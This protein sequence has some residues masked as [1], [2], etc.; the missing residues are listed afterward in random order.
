M[1]TPRTGPL[2]APPG[3][4]PEAPARGG[5]VR[6]MVPVDGKPACAGLLR[7]VAALA[8]PQGIPWLAVH[9]E[10]PARFRYARAEEE[11]LADHL[12]LAERLGAEVI[13]IQPSGL[14]AAPDFLA[15]A[16]TRQVTTL[17][18][19]RSRR[20]RWLNR[21]TGSFL[22]D[23]VHGGRELEVRVIPYFPE[24]APGRPGVAPFEAPGLRRI[25]TVL[26]ATV[27]ATAAGFLARPYLDLADIIMLYMLCIAVVAAR[28]GRWA[29]LLATGLGIAALDFFFVPPRFTLAVRD[30]RHLGT[31]GIML[32]VGWMVANLAEHIRAQA[33]MALERERHTGALYRMGAVLAEGGPV[34]AIRTR[35][36]GYLAGEL[37][38]PAVLLLAD[39]KG[40][41]QPRG[42]SGHTLDPDELAV[43]Q[44]A[45]EHG[46]PTGR[47]TRNLPG[48]RALFLPL[49]QT[50]HPVGVL[51]WFGEAA[52]GGLDPDR[53]TLL[54]T[55][56]SQI[57]LALE[58]ARLAEER[59]EARIRAEHEHLR[60]TLLSTLSHDLRTP[61]GTITGATTTL[62]EPGPEAS[63]ED[64]RWLLATIHQEAGRLQRL[65]NNLLDL[66][67]LETGE[68]R[69]AKEWI[70]VEE[71]VGSALSRLEEPLADRP[72]ELRLPEAWVPLDPVLF[73][74]VLLNLLDNALKF[75]PAGSPLEI[76][77][78]VTDTRAVWTVADR[79]PGIPPG[80]EERIFDK[81]FRGR[82]TSGTPGAGLGLAICRGIIQAHGGTIRADA[83]PGPGARFIIE[84]P[85]DG[86]PPDLSSETP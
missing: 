85:I 72:L 61:L 86:Q 45:L 18:L 62:L 56:G 3:A 69:V 67:R 33:R 74:Q 16:R 48:S 75:S 39:A 79:G 14:R 59:T 52:G 9:C 68:V 20:P 22:E 35:V 6:W 82:G 43:A 7:A 54:S 63:P 58:R 30:L 51:A 12:R 1:D 40:G 84:L 25:G 37:G 2:P 15:L 55:L 34:E 83:G 19:G 50:E 53:L 32:G 21:L 8:A 36:E 46:E 28:F 27:L 49:P 76:D 77:C 26:L 71:V 80:E 23:L 44:W 5:P 11:R 78:R 70:P 13:Q 65:V 42:E 66:T 73:E 41:L 60:S 47:G 17:L 38:T 64:Q 81:L 10:K 4:E 57:S 24:E 31:F 29:A